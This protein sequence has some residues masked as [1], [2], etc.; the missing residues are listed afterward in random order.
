MKNSVAFDPLQDIVVCSVVPFPYVMC[1]PDP[2][3][4]WDFEFTP[5]GGKVMPETEP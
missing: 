3:S 5:S 4:Q 2:A 1:W